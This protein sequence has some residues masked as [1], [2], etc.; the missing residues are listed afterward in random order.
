MKQLIFVSETSL[1]RR[2]RC[3]VLVD[4]FCESL[5][6]EE[7]KGKRLGKK[8][9]LMKERKGCII[10]AIVKVIEAKGTVEVWRASQSI[11]GRSVS[12]L[13]KARDSGSK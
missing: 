10:I 8:D 12:T 7:W 13:A 11:L 5:R 2:S 1:P 9:K 3:Y 6:R 4:T